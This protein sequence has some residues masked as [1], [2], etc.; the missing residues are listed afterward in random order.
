[1]AI[2]GKIIR[3]QLALLRPLT[4]NASLE[5]PEGGRLW[6]DSWCAMSKLQLTGKTGSCT[7]TAV[8]VAGDF[9]LFHPLPLCSGS[10]LTADDYMGD[11]VVLDEQAAWALFGGSNVAG[12]DVECGGRPYPIA[13]VVSREKDFATKRACED[14]AVVYMSMDAFQALTQASICTYEIVM[15]DPISGY[16][17]NLVTEKFPVGDGLI[18][19]NTGRYSLKNLWTVLREFGVRSMNT[20]A[21]IYPY[22]ENAA[23]M[24]EDHAALALTLC[25]LFALFPAVMVVYVAVRLAKKTA[26]AAAEAAAEA[27]EE[28]VEENR[29]KH[30]IRTG[31]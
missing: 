13:G 24:T 26:V 23:R 27:I 28:K 10:Y 16:A 22:W 12:M 25:V 21:V 17:K 4:T 2:S 29:E 15:P 9:F 6:N 8:G 18:V 3:S 5:A 14:M 20:H 1:M 11:R 19:Q 31:I 30:Y 7:V